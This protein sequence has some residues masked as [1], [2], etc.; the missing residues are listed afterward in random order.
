M[1]A[2]M[3]NRMRNFAQDEDGALIVLAL[4]FFLLMTMMGGV[5]IDIIKYETTRT[6][7]SQT[8]DRCTLMAASLDQRLDPETVLTDCVTKAGL[9]GQLQDVVV[10]DGLNSR[11]VKAIAKADTKP[12]FMHLIGIDTFDAAAGSRAVQKITNLELSLVLDV[13]GSMEGAKL[14]NLK[15]A[16][17]DF[18]ETMLSNDTGGR[19]AIALVPYNGQVNLGSA[20]RSK[21]NA[22]DNPEV[23]G[24]NC[25]DLPSDVYSTAS[26]SRLRQM[27]MTAHADS[28]S[29]TWMANGY[30]SYNDGWAT[31]YARNRWCPPSTG[32]VVRMPNDNVASLQ[33]QINGL[34]AIGATSINAGMK[35]GLTLLD[36]ASRGLFGEM[37][38]Q[39]AMDADLANRPFDYDDN[40]TMKVIVLMTDGEHFAEERMNDGF[41][42][43]PSPIYRARNTGEYSIRHASRPGPNKYYVPHLNA[44]QNSAFSSGSGSTRQD[45][46]DVWANQRVTW[47]AWQLYARALGTN[48]DTRAIQYAAAMDMLRTKTETNAMDAQLQQ[49]CT[50]AKDRHVIVFGIAFEAPANGQAQILQCASS[51]QHYFNAQGLSIGTAFDAIANNLTMLKLT[52]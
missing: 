13:S 5:A 9:G 24:V 43:G 39:G 17:N 15:A 11:D 51:P 16:A 27:P 7:L 49:A 35:W 18:V 3:T 31:P 21:F 19:T 48:D 4:I 38:N 34:T 2:T 32:N 37:A 23:D 42:K 25:I 50:L 22:A 28:F 26:M 1:A 20:L 10:L 33:A 6:Q 41:R 8:L 52:Q 30:V 12:F 45:W 36:P 14:T 44:W 47:V 40:D 29:T 46:E